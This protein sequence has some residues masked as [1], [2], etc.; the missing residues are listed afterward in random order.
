MSTSDLTTLF[1]TTRLADSKGARYGVKWATALVLLTVLCQYLSV[2]YQSNDL[3]FQMASLVFCIGAVLVVLPWYRFRLVS[4]AYIV[5][6]YLVLVVQYMY[7]SDVYGQSL[8]AFLKTSYTFVYL[9]LIVPCTFVLRRT[10]KVSLLDKVRD[11]TTV[12]CI[13]L[14]V[15][16]FLHAAAGVML[17]E[18]EYVSARNGLARIAAP[19]IMPLAYLYSVYMLT[20]KR[21]RRRRDYLCA[22]S[23]LAVAMIVDQG[24]VMLMM[25]LAATCLIFFAKRGAKRQRVILL[26]TALI[27]VL[28]LVASGYLNALIDPFSVNSSTYSRSNQTHYLEYQYYWEKFIENPWLGIGMISVDSPYYHLRAGGFLF[29]YMDDAGIIGGLAGLG[30]SALFLILLPIC[31]FSRIAFSCNSNERSLYLALVLFIVMSLVSQFL[32]F[33]FLRTIWPLIF[34]LFETEYLMQKGYEEN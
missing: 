15:A 20:A 19:S 26:A 23:S 9:L 1:F 22:I 31:W 11:M 33:P 14:L 6:F 28:L 5:A 7:T 17:V 32:I 25:L 27:I 4:T 10:A 2:L 18:F 8:L 30:V 34:A 24:R 29:F 3:L 16:V 12:L 13:F 21:K